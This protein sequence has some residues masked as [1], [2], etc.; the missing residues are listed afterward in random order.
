MAHAKVIQVIATHDTRGTGKG[1]DVCRVVDQFFTLEGE[2]MW[3][4]DHH[5]ERLAAEAKPVMPM[6]AEALE[7]I[8]FIDGVQKP[9]PLTQPEFYRVY[10]AA[11]RATVPGWRDRDVESHSSWKNV[12][13]AY[14]GNGTEPCKNCGEAARDQNHNGSLA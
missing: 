2:L 8:N 10:C 11:M 13:H 7:L 4:R 5:Q 6:P 14:V 3:E 1:G 9:D 12:N